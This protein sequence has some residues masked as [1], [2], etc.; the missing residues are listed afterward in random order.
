M[1]TAYP[2][3]GVRI[4]VMKF[5]PTNIVPR[6][7]EAADYRSHFTEAVVDLISDADGLVSQSVS[8]G[9]IRVGPH[10]KVDFLFEVVNGHKEMIVSPPMEKI[11]YQPVGI[12]FFGKYGGIGTEDFPTR[13]VTADPFKRLVLRVHDANVHGNSFKFSVI[14]QREDTGQLGVIDP[15]VDNA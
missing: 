13:T 7:P 11:V 6:N 9:P 10:A 4:T 1:S 2:I 15:Q 14:I 12:S 8:D 3:A 5:V